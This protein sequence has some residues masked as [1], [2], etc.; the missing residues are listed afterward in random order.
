MDVSRRTQ[1]AVAL[2]SVV[3]FVGAACGGA[4]KHEAQSS[5]P[6][7]PAS[8]PAGVVTKAVALYAKQLYDKPLKGVGCA[9]RTAVAGVVVQKCFAVFVAGSCKMFTVT[10]LRASMAVELD[11]RDACPGK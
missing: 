5:P 9:P 8:S 7:A 6:T 11:P 2:I 3:V 4:H 1:P 10:G